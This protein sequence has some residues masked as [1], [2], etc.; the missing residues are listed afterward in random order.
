MTSRKARASACALAELLERFCVEHPEEWERC[1]LW[2][3]E[4]GLTHMIEML[5]R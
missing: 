4:S 5:R 2:P 3:T 1:R